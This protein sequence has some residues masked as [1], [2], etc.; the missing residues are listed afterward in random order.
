[1]NKTKGTENVVKHQ[2][3]IKIYNRKQYLLHFYCTIAYEIV[4]SLYQHIQVGTTTTT[5][6]DRK[7]PEQG[8]PLSHACKTIL[9]G[10]AK[11]SCF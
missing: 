8:L 7:T 11:V 1:M 3:F 2:T 5:H 6:W 4:Y 10:N 9:T